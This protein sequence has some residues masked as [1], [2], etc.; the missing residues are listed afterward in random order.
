MPA[1][2]RT[3]DVPPVEIISK[4]IL[5]RSAA[6]STTPF[7]SETLIKALFGRIHHLM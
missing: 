1:F 5:S 3:A 6:K 7:L 4:P 2:L